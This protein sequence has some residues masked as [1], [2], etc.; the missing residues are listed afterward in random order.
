M[1]RRELVTYFGLTFLISWLGALAVVAPKLLHG[2]PVGKFEGLMMFPV[3]LLGPSISGIALTLV[4][5]GRSGLRALGSRIVR[6]RLP[7]LAVLLVPFVLVAC[8]LRGMAVVL[9]PVFMPNDFFIGIGFG[10]L[11]GA[12]EEIGWT[13]FALPRLLQCGSA[14]RQGLIL[15]VLWGLWHLPVVDFLGAA[16]PHGPFWLP[17]A[18][19]FIVAMT[20]VRLLIVWLYVNTQSIGMAQLLHA[21]S[22]GALVVLSPQVSPFQEVQWYVIYAAALWLVVGVVRLTF[23]KHLKGQQIQ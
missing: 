20:A 16:T 15:G 7:W 5:E 18:L 3:M 10:L 4:Y 12:L 22:T 19:A 11:A 1:A 8:V 14:A 6:F 9:S 17:F 23:G 13:G 2:M 21:A